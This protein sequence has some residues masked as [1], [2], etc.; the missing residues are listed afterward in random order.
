MSNLDRIRLLLEAELRFDKSKRD[1]MIQQAIR[2]V[3]DTIDF[4]L[5]SAS[6]RQLMSCRYCHVPYK[7][8]ENG[9]RLIPPLN[10]DDWWGIMPRYQKG[11]LGTITG[12]EKCPNCGRRLE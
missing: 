2:D 9:D 8:F 10:G 5:K 11:R 7:V 1:E 4:E 6:W 3:E 12:V